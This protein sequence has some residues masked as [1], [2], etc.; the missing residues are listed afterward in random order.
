MAQRTIVQ[1]TDDMDGSEASESV[2]FSLDGTAYVIDLSDT[3]AAQLRDALAPYVAAA[4]RD[5]GRGRRRKVTHISSGR[6]SRGSGDIDPKTV[7]AWAAEHGIAISARGRI[8]ADIVAQYQQAG[9]WSARSTRPLAQPG[10]SLCVCPAQGAVECFDV[11][12][13]GQ[14]LPALSAS[15]RRRSAGCGP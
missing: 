6:R 3:N 1:L 10:A 14:L 5:S 13:V 12:L 11:R 7:R 2:S 15:A 8:P 9:G 4:R